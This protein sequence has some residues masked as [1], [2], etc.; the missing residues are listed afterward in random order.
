VKSGWKFAEL[1]GKPEL[2]FEYSYAS[3]DGDPEDGRRKTFSGV[4]G[5]RDKMYGRI[6]LFDW[7]NLKNSQFNLEISPLPKLSLLAEF[8]DFKLAEKRDGWSLNPSL[9]RDPSGA[10]GDE[11][12]RELDLIATWETSITGKAFAGRLTVQLG[13]CR[14]WAGNFAQKVA[15]DKNAN[16]FF[17]QLQY[18]I[19]IQP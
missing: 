13:A 18:R 1:P 15:A 6:N 4:F 3:G 16:W 7:R 9:Y 8:H 17:C 5:S 2:S 11:V 19:D 10:A 14:F 12:G